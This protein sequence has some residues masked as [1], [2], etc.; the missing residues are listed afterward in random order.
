MGR[1]IADFVCHDQKLVIELDGGQHGDTANTMADAERD[2]WFNSKG[3]RVLRF[4]NNDVLANTDGVLQV[5]AEE[6]RLAR[7]Q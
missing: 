6:I 4:W 7:N 5:I 2:D 1:Y 3:Y